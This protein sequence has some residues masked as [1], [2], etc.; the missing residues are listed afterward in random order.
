MPIL[1]DH[2]DYCYELEFAVRDYEVDMFGVVNHANYTHY[3]EHT[4]HSF[5]DEIGVPVAGLRAKGWNPL[6]TRLEVHYKSS[7]FSGDKFVVQMSVDSISRVKFAFTQDLFRLS[8]GQFCTHARVVGTV[9]NPEGKPRMPEDFQK[10][11]P[12]IKA[13]SRIR[14]NRPDRKIR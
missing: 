3:L 4:R 2:P 9:L 14:G 10:M 1:Q 8:D 13:T 12:F 6:V 7:L 5:L 11:T